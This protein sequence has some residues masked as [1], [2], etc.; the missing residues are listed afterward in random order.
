M[1]SWDTDLQLQGNVGTI[2]GVACGLEGLPA[3]YRDPINDEIVLS[4]I[5]GYL[6]ILHI[7]SD[8]WELA[9]SGLPPA[10]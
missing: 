8:A 5:S 2:L 7:P 10:R 9:R 6:N 4:G 3:H 1:C